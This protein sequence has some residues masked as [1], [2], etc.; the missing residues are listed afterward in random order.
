MVPTAVKAIGRGVVLWVGLMSGAFS[1]GRELFLAYRATAGQPATPN[2]TL[3]LFGHLSIVAF[4]ICAAA[5]WWL[6]HAEVVRLKAALAAKN[7]DPELELMRHELDEELGKLN[8]MHFVAL[9]QVVS[10]GGRDADQLRLFLRQQ[11]IE[12]DYTQTETLLAEI[13]QLTGLIQPEAMG[14]GWRYVMNP[15]WRRVLIEWANR[16]RGHRFL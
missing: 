4:V 9:H 14:P 1:L 16:T 8:A 3:A 12:R 15:D 5:M 2:Q 13:A 7:A 11:N 10:R 6:E